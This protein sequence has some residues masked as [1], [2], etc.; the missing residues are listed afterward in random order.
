MRIDFSRGFMSY[1]EDEAEQTGEKQPKNESLEEHLKH[2]KAQD[3]SSCPFVKAAGN[4]DVV[5]PQ[6]SPDKKAELDKVADAIG[7][8]MISLAQSVGKK[9]AD[10]GSFVVKPSME[11]DAAAG[12]EKPTGGFQVVASVQGGQ[13][14]CEGF[15]DMLESDLGI[16][17]KPQDFYAGEGESRI[18]TH[19]TEEE[20]KVALVK[21]AELEK[22][23]QEKK[24][25]AELKAKQKA[26]KAKIDETISL[27][28]YAVIAAAKSVNFHVAQGDFAPEKDKID[29]AIA[30]KKD[31]DEFLSGD[32]GP[33]LDDKQKAQVDALAKAVGEIEDSYY[34]A[35]HTPVGKVPSYEVAKPKVS[36][37]KPTEPEL[38]GGIAAVHA[39]I[40]NAVKSINHHID[41]GDFKPNPTSIANMQKA[42]AWVKLHC[43]DGE[44][45]E[46]DVK[47]LYDTMCEIAESAKTGWHKK[48]GMMKPLTGE[49][50]AKPKASGHKSGMEHMME[51]LLHKK[52]AGSAPKTDEAPDAHEYDPSAWSHLASDKGPGYL[53]SVADGLAGNHAAI[54]AT[55]GICF[56][57]ASNGVPPGMSG[58]CEGRKPI[59]DKKIVS[60][61]LACAAATMKDLKDRFPNMKFPHIDLLFVSDGVEFTRQPDGKTAICFNADYGDVSYGG[62]YTY[63][64]PDSRLPFDD[65]RHALAHAIGKGGIH[66]EWDKFVRGTYG[67]SVKGFLKVMKEKVSKYASSYIYEALAETFSMITSHDYKPGTLPRPIEDFIY[68]KMLGEQK[69]GK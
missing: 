27:A 7:A 59:A 16:S 37:E 30:A 5:Q 20:S 55:L 36:A 8:A 54:N 56:S 66:N 15:L 11:W 67:P 69:K 50:P 17:R 51:A 57:A 44:S 2:C 49:A 10:P 26:A 21:A 14:E 4:E 18:R 38:Q 31:V 61:T 58:V 43:P 46:K 29:G 63:G 6:L 25:D 33:L 41:V 19:V 64:H 53:K 32:M 22:K 60:D 35:K 24:Q 62:C 48:I 45:G 23:A 52:S 1:A 28:T 9:F 65:L 34:K 68:T 12:I 40:L 42:A 39:A 13:K 47:A 3:P